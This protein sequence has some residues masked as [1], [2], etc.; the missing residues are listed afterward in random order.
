MKYEYSPKNLVYSGRFTKMVICGEGIKGTKF[1]AFSY[2]VLGSKDNLLGHIGRF[3]KLQ[4]WVFDP[5]SE[6][7]FSG[8]HVYLSLGCLNEISGFIQNLEGRVKT[9]QCI[10]DVPNRF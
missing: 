2:S 5:V 6:M 10:N 3:S 9:Y 1:H 8:E 4:M 7:K